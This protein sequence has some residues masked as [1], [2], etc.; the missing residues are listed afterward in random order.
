MRTPEQ[1]IARYVPLIVPLSAA[2]SASVHVFALL[3]GP[4]GGVAVFC[5]VACSSIAYAIGSAIVSGIILGASM[6]NAFPSLP[7]GAAD[8]HG[9]ALLSVAAGF[10][11]AR[12]S[13]LSDS[14]LLSR[15]LRRLSSRARSAFVF[16]AFVS[17][18][19]SVF[20]VVSLGSCALGFVAAL[21]MASRVPKAPPVARPW[22]ARLATAAL[23][24]LA[25]VTALALV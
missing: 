5:I 4:T 21:V 25:V 18:G 23:S 15:A 9:A 20:S 22:Q 10:V 13:M 6:L 3:G 19:A 16:L 11:L 24:G 17:L 1:F 12:R 14:A 8:A 2:I 7:I